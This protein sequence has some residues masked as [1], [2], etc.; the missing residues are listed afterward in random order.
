MKN[1]VK[2]I[3]GSGCLI[4]GV[5][6]MGYQFRTFGIVISLIFIVAGLILLLAANGKSVTVTNKDSTDEENN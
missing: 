1:I 4:S 5:I 3:T 2:A 6:L